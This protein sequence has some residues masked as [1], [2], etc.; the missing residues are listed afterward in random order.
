MKGLSYKHRELVPTTHIQ[1]QAW[2]WRTE[3]WNLLTSLVGCID[4]VQEDHV[5]VRVSLL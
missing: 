2:Q 5:L 1:S 4:E 3:P